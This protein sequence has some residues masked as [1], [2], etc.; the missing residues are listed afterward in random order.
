MNTLSKNNLRKFPSL[1]LIS[2]VGAML[3]AGCSSMP[4]AY[5]GVTG[6]QILE[7]NTDSARL[8]YTLAAR[9]N[10]ALDQRKLQGACQKVLG[11]GKSYQ[12]EILNVQENA[13]PR[14][15]ETK[16]GVNL[17]KTKATFALSNTQALYSNDDLATRQALEA[18][19]STLSTVVYRCS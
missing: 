7:K 2:V 13:N 5:N 10:Q 16:Y 14:A 18:Q 11:A 15:D 19:P 3:L 9:S 1:L 8:S 17:P 12:I 4:S 6:Y